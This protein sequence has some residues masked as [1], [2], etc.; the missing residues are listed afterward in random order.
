MTI[1]IDLFAAVIVAALAV[2]IAA[3]LILLALWIADVKR[4]VLW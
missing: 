2:V 3:P 4:G 1:P